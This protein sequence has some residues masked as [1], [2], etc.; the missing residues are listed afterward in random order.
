MAATSPPFLPLSS[1]ERGP[2]GE[3]VLRDDRHEAVSPDDR[4]LLII[5]D[6][7]K[8]AKILFDLAHEKGFKAL[9]AADGAA[10]LQLAD[11][12]RPLAII[13]DMGLP[14]MDGRAVIEKLHQN[15]DTQ[16]IPVHIISASDQPQD[17]GS[18][19]AIGYLTKP[20]TLESLHGAFT[21]IEQAVDTTIK[22]VLIVED[23]AV[24]RT[25]LQE[26]LGSEEIVTSTVETGQEAY[27]ILH[28]SAFDC[29]ILDLGLRDM[30]GE[31]LL[32]RIR[33]DAAT[34]ALPVIIYTGKDLSQ[35]ESQ[36]L[37]SSAASVIIKGAKSPERLLDEVEHL[38]DDVS[39][40]L[41]TVETELPEDAQPP[42]P[43][44]AQE[45]VF[46][47]KTVLLVD[48][49]M[50]NMFALTSVFE[51]KGLD[52]VMAESGREALDVLQEHPDI[53]LVLMDIMMPE[54]D[55]YEAMQAIRKQPR[56]ANLPIIALTANAMKGDRQKCIEAGANDYLSKPIDMDKLFSLLRVWLY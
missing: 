24:M 30:P 33:A 49:D 51:D 25:S 11:Q 53:D 2:G 32:A 8:F 39:L 18:M 9:T 6:D 27:D 35:E 42:S 41:H 34:A 44:N 31:K 29:M 43:S 47:E 19:D 48:D 55:G 13:L 4:F 26:L 54:M 46:S 14:D 7:A 22:R 17:A 5:E 52:V 3:F 36:T 23:D 38:L 1:Q 10:G 40:F 12:Y 50:R 45:T 37:A 16:S 15:P 56:F 21:T 28:S 20:V